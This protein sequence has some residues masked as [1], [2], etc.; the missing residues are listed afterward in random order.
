MSEVMVSNT[1]KIRLTAPFTADRL[2]QFL[3]A[4]DVELDRKVEIIA[5]VHWPDNGPNN[6]RTG[7]VLVASKTQ[8]RRH[9]MVG[10]G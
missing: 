2:A 9:E 5:E 10:E 7:V 3:D 6:E 1:T 8:D 4:I